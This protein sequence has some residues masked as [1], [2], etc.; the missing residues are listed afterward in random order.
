MVAGMIL[1]NF[2]AGLHQGDF[3][4]RSLFG[5]DLEE[6]LCQMPKCCLV[7]FTPT[8]GSKTDDVRWYFKR[9]S[10]PRTGIQLGGNVV[11]KCEEDLSG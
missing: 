7:L 1:V 9:S 3:R 4:V 6:R 2:E 10:A 8:A 5:E 11:L